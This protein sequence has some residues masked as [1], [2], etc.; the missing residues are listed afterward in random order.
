MSVSDMMQF[1]F[2]DVLQTRILWD[3]ISTYQLIHNKRTGERGEWREEGGER[4]E[5]GEGKRE[6]EGERV[7]E[8]EGEER[9]GRGMKEEGESGRGWE[10]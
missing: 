4:R 5:K 10:N 7:K 3:K 6:G 8:R 9:G 2:H 1:S